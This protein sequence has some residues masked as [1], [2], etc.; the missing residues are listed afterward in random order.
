[1]PRPVM[2]AT[3]VRAESCPGCRARSG[4]P[5]GI[6]DVAHAVESRSLATELGQADPSRSTGDDLR[7]EMSDALLVWLT[8][9]EY[10]AKRATCRKHAG[11]RP[12]PAP[13]T[14]DMTA[15]PTTVTEPVNPARIR[16][17]GS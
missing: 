5:T 8:W 10:R 2:H 6:P 15:S 3:Q 17:R 7:G 12:R 13:S 14:C 16:Q 9:R 1:M 4:T 11:T